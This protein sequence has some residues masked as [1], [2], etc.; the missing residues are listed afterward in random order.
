[1]TDADYALWLAADT[2]VR[3]IGNRKGTM[4][5]PCED[6]C[7]AFALEMRAEGRCDG[8]FPGEVPVGEFDRLPSG[9]YGYTSE[10]ARQEARRASWRVSRQRQ[11]LQAAT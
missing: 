6:C 3:S 10:E 11:R 8:H 1:M 7:A 5:T 2:T 4:G 9:H